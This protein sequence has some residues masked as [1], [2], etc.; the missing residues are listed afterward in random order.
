MKWR[1]R[2]LWLVAAC[3]LV[4]AAM[5]LGRR[6]GEGLE[7]VLQVLTVDDP[8]FLVTAYPPYDSLEAVA[9]DDI[10]AS[11]G[12]LVRSI[13]WARHVGNPDSVGELRIRNRTRAARK[14]EVL[15]SVPSTPWMDETFDLKTWHFK[16]SSFV[17]AG[18]TLAEGTRRVSL[19]VGRAG[20]LLSRDGPWKETILVPRFESGSELLVWLAFVGA[21]GAEV[22]VYADGRKVRIR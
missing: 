1:S 3:L 18:A 11:R 14:L 8:R 5:S 21:R 6:D 7:A 12:G 20:F 9:L 19:P 22:E 4:V 13:R 17:Y 2:W 16:R 15:I 10:M